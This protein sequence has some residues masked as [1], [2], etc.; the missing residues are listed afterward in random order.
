MAQKTEGFVAGDLVNL[1][2]RALNILQMRL[3]FP[4]RTA[5][6]SSTPV[7]RAVTQQTSCESGHNSPL[8]SRSLPSSP[9]RRQRHEKPFRPLSSSGLMMSH[10][11]STQ[12]LID[13]EDRRL[14]EGDFQKAL[15]GFVPLALRDL[16]LHYSGHSDFSHVGGITI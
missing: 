13:A 15:E 4:E 9:L 3:A 7:K 8:L 10:C 1:I 12:T 2:D 11:S 6:F 5:D 16:G 14:S